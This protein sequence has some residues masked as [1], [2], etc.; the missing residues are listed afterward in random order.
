MNGTRDGGIKTYW[1]D[2]TKDSLYIDAGSTNASGR[3]ILKIAEVK[4]PGIKMEELE[5]GAEHIQ[6]DCIGYDLYD[7]TDYT[8]FSCITARQEYFERM[9]ALPRWQTVGKS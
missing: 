4:W 8:N 9:A 6:T 7:R 5:F 1:P 2:D 3:D